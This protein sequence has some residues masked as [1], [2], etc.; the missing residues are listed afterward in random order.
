MQMVCS[1]RSIASLQNREEAMVAE[2]RGWGSRA[3]RT[4]QNFK[5]ETA[6][7]RRIITERMLCMQIEDRH[8]GRKVRE[9]EV[10]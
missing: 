6:M 5:H 4:P 8:T 2:H 3:V 10:F 7:A 1:G 9:D